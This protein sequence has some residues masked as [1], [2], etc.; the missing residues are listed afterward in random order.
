VLEVV[1]VL[2]LTVEL[3][4]VLVA[5]GCFVGEPAIRK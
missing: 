5:V 2:D 1:V 3:G 4:L